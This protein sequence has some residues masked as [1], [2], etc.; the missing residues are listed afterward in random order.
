M[1]SYYFTVNK[2]LSSLKNHTT[3][4]QSTAR[5]FNNYTLAMIPTCCGH[6]RLLRYLY[7]LRTS[8]IE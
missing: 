4:R 3:D 6:Y 7:Y 5:A 1:F 2:N 8:T